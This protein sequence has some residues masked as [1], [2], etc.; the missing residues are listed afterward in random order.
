MASNEAVQDVL[1][2]EL[3]ADRLVESAAEEATRGIAAGRWDIFRCA[4]A[5]ALDINHNQ[6]RRQEKD[7][8]SYFDI[9]VEGEL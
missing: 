9:K 6:A 3:T 5:V 2:R 7:L 1:L 8:L 4:V